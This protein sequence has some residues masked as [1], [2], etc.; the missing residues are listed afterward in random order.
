MQTFKVFLQD[1]KA[2]GQTYKNFK[3]LNDDYNSALKEFHKVF[4]E[5]IRTDSDFYYSFSTWKSA[6]LDLKCCL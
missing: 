3:L 1:A 6:W 4:S 2:K 5:W